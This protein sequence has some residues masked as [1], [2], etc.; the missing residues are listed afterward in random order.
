MTSIREWVA[1]KRGRYTILY[2]M[3]LLG[4]LLLLLASW[5]RHE[6]GISGQWG[7]AS[8]GMSE[9]DEP[10]SDVSRDNNEPAT[11][12]GATTALG[13]LLAKDWPET[14]L[15]LYADNATEILSREQFVQASQKRYDMRAEMKSRAYA[16]PLDEHGRYVLLG[17]NR[18]FAIDRSADPSFDDRHLYLHYEGIAAGMEKPVVRLFPHAASRAVEQS[19]HTTEGNS[20]SLPSAE[21][22]MHD[23]AMTLPLGSMAALADAWVIHIDTI[24]TLREGPKRYLIYFR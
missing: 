23:D 17:N 15:L 8:D 11:E 13:Q 6:Q 12:I 1:T 21:L 7:G 20:T 9:T 3:G 18:F 14:D 2:G 4:L 19:V 16:A 22:T 5:Q 24:S 10:Q